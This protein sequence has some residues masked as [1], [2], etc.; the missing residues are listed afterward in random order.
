MYWQRI[1]LVLYICN[2]GRVISHFIESS[3]EILLKSFLNK[4]IE[5]VASI[6]QVGTQVFSC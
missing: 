3:G 4:Q 1:L 5:L 2:C 6:S